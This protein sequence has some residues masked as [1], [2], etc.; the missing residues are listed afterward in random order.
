[1]VTLRG[2]GRGDAEQSG[3]SSSSG[4][5]RQQRPARSSD[6]P[7]RDP[8]GTRSRSTVSRP[9]ESALSNGFNAED[10]DEQNQAD[11][12][13]HEDEDMKPAKPVIR[14]SARLQNTA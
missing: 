14:K 3:S 10:D 12:E 8:P 1:M 6:T 13:T 9:Q 4:P 5:Q 11:S 7:P 2:R